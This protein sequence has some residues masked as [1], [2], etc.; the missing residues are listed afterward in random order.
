MPT[1]LR[2]R[3][4]ERYQHY[5]NRTPPWIKLHNA[6]LDD[7]EFTCL[8]PKDKAVLML[9]WLLCSRN[10]NRVPDDADWIGKR[11]SV[12]GVDL[13][14]LIA[15][16]FVERV[17]DGTEQPASTVASKTLA[18][19]SSVR[20][21][22]R[23]EKRESREEKERETEERKQPRNSRGREPRLSVSRRESVDRI[24]RLYRS[25]AK[26][27]RYDETP[28]RIRC[29]AAVLELLGEP[30]LTAYLR[31]FFADPK[32]AWHRENGY[33]RLCE[34]VISRK[35]S[36]NHERIKARLEE[37]AERAGY[38]FTW[39]DEDGVQDQADG[40]LRIGDQGDGSGR[41]PDSGDDHGGDPADGGRGELLRP[42]SLR[43]LPGQLR[44]V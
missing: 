26:K 43:R 40:Q 9:F 16:G 28:A 14:A 19:C 37:L 25:L 21:T 2:A 4:W 33:D 11:I 22:S 13:S 12:D 23:E 29:V 10:D 44:V 39:E 1:F 42:E 41:D 24:F 8:S 7:Y 32:F 18:T 15:S 34:Y 17:S 6:I 36:H 31:A 38:E 5:A 20:S 30:D 3:N 27:S 35:A